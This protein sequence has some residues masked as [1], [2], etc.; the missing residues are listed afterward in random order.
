MQTTTVDVPTSD[1]VADAYL[2]RP[3]GDGPFPAVVV[4]MDAFGLRPRLAEMAERIAA[5]GYL[6]L[7][8]NLFY[9]AGRAPLIGL[10]GLADHEQRG[11]IFGQLM[12]FIRALTP[13]WRRRSP[14]PA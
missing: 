12:P 7:V 1:G 9:R 5:R 3:D 11:A 6:V 8:P 14:R 13:P 10:S 4:F 2:V